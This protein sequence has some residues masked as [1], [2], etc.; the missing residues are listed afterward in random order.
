MNGRIFKFVAA[1][2]L[3]LIGQ[4]AQAGTV[5]YVYTDPQGTPLAE[6]DASGNITATFDYKP[7][8]SQVLG[9]PKAA[10]GYTGHVNDPDTG[11]VYMQARYYDPAVGRFL[12]TD[13][14]GPSPGNT[15]TLNRYAYVGNDPIGKVDP[16]GNQEILVSELPPMLEPVKLGGVTGEDQVIGPRGTPLRPLDQLPEGSRD[17][18]GAGK[19]F[20][21]T[22]PRETPP[23]LYCDSKTSRNPG[24]DQHNND[25]NIPKVQGGNNEEA[26]RVDSCRTCNTSKGGRT[27]AQ[28]YESLRN[29]IKQIFTPKPP[30]PPPPPPKRFA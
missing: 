19:D 22:K 8:G 9:T 1:L 25:H 27:P 17:G 23:C 24:P 12:S 29:K 26:N 10:P 15:S 18:P 11:F 30:P 13:S 2:L 20:P 5:T 4:L 21:R 14:V 16:S 28:W 6:A 3:G 7:Y